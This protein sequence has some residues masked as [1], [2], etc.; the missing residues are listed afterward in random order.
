MPCKENE[1]DICKRTDRITNCSTSPGVYPGYR[2]YILP[3]GRGSYGK[4]ERGMDDLK[5]DLMR[6]L[7]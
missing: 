6:D 1:H 5:D 4:K 2:I 3:Q 7:L